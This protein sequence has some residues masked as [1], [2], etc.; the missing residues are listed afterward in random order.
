MQYASRLDR[1][2]TETA[3]AVSADTINWANKGHKIFPF[4]LGDINL[5]TPSNIQEAA[6]KHMHDGKTGYC[7]AEGIPELRDALSQDVGHR[8]GINYT[9]EKH[10][11]C[12]VFFNKKQ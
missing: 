11:L 10:T 5:P 4:H 3:F 8:R 1:L 7:P 6:M 9:A 12:V 2:G